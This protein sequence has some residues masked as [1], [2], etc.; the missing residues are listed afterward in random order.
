MAD[1]DKP[2]LF[3]CTLNGVRSV[4]AEALYGARFGPSVQSCGMMAGPPNGFT[5]AVLAEIGLDV[6]DHEPQSFDDLSAD[7]FSLVIS[8]SIEAKLAAESWAAK[9][10]ESGLRHE[11]WD[12]QEPGGDSGNR[13]SQLEGYRQVRD[14]IAN[15]L[16]AY[17]GADRVK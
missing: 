7:D 16:D 14:E 13:D 5:A 6:T 10:A 1:I 15:R 8:M 4:M 9:A 2:V 3:A 11:H 17:F 12:I